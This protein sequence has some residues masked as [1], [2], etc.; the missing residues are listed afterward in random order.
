MYFG[1]GEFAVQ[2]LEAL[3]EAGIQPLAVVTTPDKPVGRDRA[4]SPSP[5]KVAA[6]ARG[7]AAA[8]AARGGRNR[9]KPFICRT[10]LRVIAQPF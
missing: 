2:P 1:T 8:P 10:G 4:H 5:V 3:L 6:A 7:C 9:K